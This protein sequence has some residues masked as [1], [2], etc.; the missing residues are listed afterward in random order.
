MNATDRSYTL[1]VDYDVSLVT[2][3][4]NDNVTKK[5]II[6]PGDWNYSFYLNFL[7]RGCVAQ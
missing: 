5:L 3:V 1:R 2:S 4:Q 7:A 6:M